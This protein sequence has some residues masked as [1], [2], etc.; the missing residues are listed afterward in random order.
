M[1]NMGD[2]LPAIW[3]TI[4]N[5]WAG[6]D[7]SSE[8]SELMRVA[9]SKE[10]Q[11]SAISGSKPEMALLLGLSCQAAGGEVDWADIATAAWLL[12]YAAADIM[13]SIEDKDAPASWWRD[14]GPAT[15]LSVATGLFFS[16]TS[17]LHRMEE[18]EITRNIAPT[19]IQDFFNCFMVMSNGQYDDLQNSNPTLEQ[20]W[21]IASAKS[22][23]F[24][25]LACRSGARL[26]I[27]EHPRSKH[28]G[29]FGHHIGLIIQILDDLGDISFQTQSV[30]PTKIEKLTR[31]L[32]VV[33]TMQ[34]IPKET[35]EKF[36]LCLQNAD[37]E[38][39]AAEEAIS[40]MDKSGAGI[41][42]LSEIE[43]HKKLAVDSLA[44]A[45]PISSAGEILAGYLDK[46][47]ASL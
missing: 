3:E 10:K 45:E 2:R 39:Q 11:E 8:F 35:R 40:I 22:G 42:L 18:Q 31:S 43:R 26:A 21:K 9:L 44:L 32:P 29:Q 46:L 36:H 14:L 28:F 19:V 47:G 15:A 41:Y 27:G 5:I 6:M 25:A 1:P 17:A 30:L 33:Y 34:V 13:D 24:F 20:Y 4:D 7:I 16:A 38:E 12:F 23:A 37:H